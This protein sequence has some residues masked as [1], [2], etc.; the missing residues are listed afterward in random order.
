MTWVSGTPIHDGGLADQEGH[1]VHLQTPPQAGNVCQRR[2]QAHRQQL[3]VERH[4]GLYD[5]LVHRYLQGP[6]SGSPFLVLIRDT[7]DHGI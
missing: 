6:R 3:R 1:G 7:A 4:Q 2:E 5:V